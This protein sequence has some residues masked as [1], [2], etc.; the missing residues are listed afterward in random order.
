MEEERQIP[1][2][3]MTSIQSNEQ[4]RDLLLGLAYELGITPAEVIAR[5]LILYQAVFR[6]TQNSIA[7]S[8][9]AKPGIVTANGTVV[10][11]FDV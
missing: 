8:V 4:F 6:E 3:T 1:E 5:A 11:T 9:G 10:C 2:T 7:R